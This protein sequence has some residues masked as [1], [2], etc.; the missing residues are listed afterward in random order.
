MLYVDNALL[1]DTSVLIERVLSRALEAGKIK[2]RAI[3]I[4]EAVLAELEHQANENKSTGLI[5]L[6][7]VKSLRERMDAYGYEMLTVGSRPSAEAIAMARQGEVDALIRQVA[8]E[9]GAVLV[10]ADRIQAEVAEAMGITVWFVTPSE[11]ETLSFESYFDDTTM[12]VHLKECVKPLAKKGKPGAWRFETLRDETLSREEVMR[13]ATEIVEAAGRMRDGFIELDRQGSTIVQLGRYRIVITKPPFSDGWEI[14][15]VRP[16]ARFT[17]ED[18]QL[19][20]KLM[21]R[22]KT[23]AEGV[24]IAGSPGMGKS[25]F[26]QALAEYYAKQGKIVKTIEAPRDLILPDEVTQYAM[27]HGT[28]EEV[29]DVLLLSRPDYTLFDEMRNTRDFLLF[30]DLRLSGIGLVGVVHATNPIDAIQ[31]FIGR[32]EL[33]MIPQVIDTVIFIK[34]G[35]PE[36]ILSLEMTVKVPA[37]MTEE[38]LARPV[39]VVKDFESGKDEYEIYSYGEETVV[40]PVSATARRE[41]PGYL[42]YAARA[43]EDY[44]APYQGRVRFTGER[45]ITVYVPKRMVSKLIGKGGERVNSIEKD[46]GLSVQV[47]SL[48][49]MPREARREKSIPFD[50][51]VTRNNV[52]LLLPSKHAGK[53]VRILIDDEP[54]L[55]AKVGKDGKVKISKKSPAGRLLEQALLEGRRVDVVSM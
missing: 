9:E 7:E 54:L 10:T 28:P 14:T 4:H 44:F 37:G 52:T 34:N 8:Y 18:Y 15:L 21:N 39:V 45:S 27:S 24:L 35:R 42:D 38:D 5:G 17:L 20:E 50:S 51:R 55:T 36:K 25:T 3:L 29:H 43:L 1:P 47:K 6:E 46:L 53:E 16:V 26:A 2:P 22:L 40:V 33:G 49:E 32:I 48:D 31:R 30:A 41:Q 11:A 23:Q 19:S 13:I 12:S